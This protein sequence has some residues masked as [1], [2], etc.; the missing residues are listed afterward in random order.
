MSSEEKEDKRIS[1]R[2][3][4][5]GAAV[6][7]VGGMLASCGSTPEPQIIEKT[8]EVEKI[9]KETVEV[10]VEVTKIVEVA[11]EGAG[12]AGPVALEVLDPSGVS[13][14]TQVH[15]PRLDTL[16]GKTI[17]LLI[18]EIWQS[19]RTAP[20]I[21]ELLQKQYPTAKI[22]PYTDLPTYSESFT[23]DQYEE[24][25]AAVKAAGCDGAI[26]GNAG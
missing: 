14:V 23:A 7:G 9:V 20:L 3:F 16:D 2:K 13:V 8:V 19:W 26:V 1:R 22:I 10:P 17:C 18:N 5:K 25:V 12:Q 21:G 15:A 6:V 24:V 11:A 4:V